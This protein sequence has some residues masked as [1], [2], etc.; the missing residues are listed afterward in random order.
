MVSLRAGT[1]PSS[2]ARML[3][4]AAREAGNV[5]GAGGSAIELFNRYLAWAT[6]QERMLAG[7]FPESEVERLLT[8]R[9]YWTIQAM[10]PIA[11]GAALT[12]F[13]TLELN[14]R[15]AEF[16]REKDSLER[17][18]ALWNVVSTP[19]TFAEHLHA[20]VVDTNVLMRH[21]GEMTQLDWAAIAGTHPTQSIAIVVPA[22]VVAELDDLKHS[23]GTMTFGGVAHQRRWLATLALGWLERTFPG[24][25]RRA[26]I[27]NAEMGDRGPVTQLYA[28]LQSDPLDHV[29]LPRADSEIIDNALRL[30]P[31]AKTVTL[32]SYD[33]HMIFTAR[34]LGLRAHKLPEAP[35]KAEETAD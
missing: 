3:L 8:T 29:A 12:G 30:S 7:S 4:D 6:A 14:A 23:N 9:R 25:E 35:E 19:R 17:A 32:A 20:V 10:D 18:M 34:H 26:L 28:V 13:V 15:T 31:L 1:D 2:A 33:T 27:R 21:K 24:V 11:Y 16:E 5:L 22:V